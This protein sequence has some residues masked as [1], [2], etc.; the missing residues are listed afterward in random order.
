MPSPGEQQTK[1]L[2]TAQ[3]HFQR[4]ITLNPTFSTSYY[5][6]AHIKNRMNDRDGAIATYEDLS[7]VEP[8]YSETDLNLGII[9]SCKAAAA[10][11]AEELNLLEKASAATREA[12]RQS[13]KPDIQCV[14]AE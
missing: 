14:A 1:C 12:A 11:G 10:A 13:L 9:Y 2:L 4:A 7:R 6:L 5:K 8:H 3:E